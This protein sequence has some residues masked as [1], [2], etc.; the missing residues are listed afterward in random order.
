MLRHTTRWTLIFSLTLVSLI[1]FVALLSQPAS[2]D[3]SPSAQ[4]TPTA[5]PPTPGPAPKTDRVGYPEGYQENFNKQV[6]AV[7]ANDKAMQV[8]DGQPFPYGSILVM[9]T[10]RTKQDAAGNI[11]KDANGRYVRD[12]LT[13]IFVMRKEPGFGTDYQQQR[14]GEWE[15]VAFR[16]DKTYSSPP[17]RTNACAAC[18]LQVSDASKDW[19]ARSNL[20]FQS[21]ASAQA[22][23]SALPNTGHDTP[24]GF[25]VELAILGLVLILTAGALVM[26]ARRV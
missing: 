19:V 18:H 26:R 16:P 8:K 3:A 17:E 24:F 14:T 10:W 12:T 21:V 2:V 15:Y 22:A 5:I 9:E 25:G 7:Y 4:T 11:E 1:A 23:P 6:R 13:G 20:F